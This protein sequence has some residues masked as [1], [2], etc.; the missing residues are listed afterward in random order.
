MERVFRYND[1]IPRLTTFSPR[2]H[3]ICT[4]FAHGGARKEEKMETNENG[5]KGYM[6]AKAEDV[7]RRAELARHEE[8]FDLATRAE[9]IAYAMGS[10]Q[11]MALLAIEYEQRHGDMDLL[12]EYEHA[13]ALHCLLM[14]IGRDMRELQDALYEEARKAS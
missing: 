5:F 14:H 12:E 1:D 6:A 13:K 10:A 9:N 4:R 11:N 2:L 8:M 3:T 7:Q